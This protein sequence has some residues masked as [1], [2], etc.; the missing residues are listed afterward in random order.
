MT[1]LDEVYAPMSR[2][3]IPVAKRAATECRPY[4]LPELIVVRG[5]PIKGRDLRAH[6]A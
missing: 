6:Q 5:W 1:E 4:N 2:L 3:G